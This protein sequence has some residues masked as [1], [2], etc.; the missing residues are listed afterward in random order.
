V[1]SP[2]GRLGCPATAVRDSAARGPLLEHFVVV[3]D[4]SL[5]VAAESEYGLYAV[6]GTT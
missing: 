4:L 2:E 3:Q 6:V 1:L 5:Y